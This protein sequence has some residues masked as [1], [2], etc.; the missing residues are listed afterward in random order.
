MG[1]REDYQA[2]IEKQFKEWQAQAQLFK[3][4]AQQMEAQAKVQLEK[5]LELLRATQ[6]QAWESFAKSKG[7]NESAWNEFRAHMDKAGEELRSAAEVMT[8]AFKQP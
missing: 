2:L 3:Q 4:A 7:A 6:A 8:R 1:M 5:N